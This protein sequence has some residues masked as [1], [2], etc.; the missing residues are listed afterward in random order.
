[1]YRRCLG[2]A[3]HRSYNMRLVL[4]C[5][6]ER[7]ERRDDVSGVRGRRCA[8]LEPGIR[9]QPPG[10]ADVRQAE[11]THVRIDAPFIFMAAS[12]IIVSAVQVGNPFVYVR[13]EDAVDPF[14]L[15]K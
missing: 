9:P 8:Y 6:K 7:R 13:I 3:I 2:A 5:A 10:V 14:P 4:K 1:M 11:I 12:K 15:P